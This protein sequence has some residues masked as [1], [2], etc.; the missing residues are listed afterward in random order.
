MVDLKKTDQDI[1]NLTKQ[2]KRLEAKREKEAEKAAAVKRLVKDLKADLRANKLTVDDLLEALGGVSSPAGKA[3][4]PGKRRRKVKAATRKARKSTAA[5]ITIPD[6]G[7]YQVA[8][9]KD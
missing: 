8:R 3:K 5:R 9:Y 1:A 4:S 6:L 2:L 7:T